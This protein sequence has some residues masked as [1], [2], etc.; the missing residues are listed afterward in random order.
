MTKHIYFIRHGESESNVD[1]ICRGPNAMLTECGRAQAQ[2]VAQLIAQIKP[3]ALISSDFPRAVDTAS[4]IA[5]YTGLPIEQQKLFGEWVQPTVF[6]GKHKNEQEIQKIFEEIANIQDNTYRHSDEEMFSNLFIRARK[7]IDFLEKYDSDRMCVVTHGG[8]LRAILSNMVF[9]ST[10]TKA[11][12]MTFF[13]LFHM[14]NT[15]ITY[16]TYNS[17]NNNWKL[18]SW[19]SNLHLSKLEDGYSQ[20]GLV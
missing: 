19:N 2:A 15:G 4:A 16:M 13:R 11:D 18:I 9:G 8:I 14:D 20:G 1:G 6:F 10:L 3:T 12:F 5:R 17:E 7:A